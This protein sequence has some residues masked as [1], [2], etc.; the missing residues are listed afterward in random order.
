MRRR[1]AE[2][3]LCSPAKWVTWY[4][5]FPRLGWGSQYLGKPVACSQMGFQPS[6]GPSDS[7]ESEWSVSLNDRTFQKAYCVMSPCQGCLPSPEQ[8]GQ[9]LPLG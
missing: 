6:M 3:G 5:G 7:C 4:L 1:E 8:N 9:S 2:K